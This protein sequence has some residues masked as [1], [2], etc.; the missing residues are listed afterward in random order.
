M[1]VELDVRQDEQQHLDEGDVRWE[2]PR[3]S[4]RCRFL[5]LLSFRKSD[6]LHLIPSR[7]TKLIST[8]LR[9]EVTPEDKQNGSRSL[10]VTSIV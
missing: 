3:R 7:E 10:S 4:G 2:H 8:L 5:R 9:P 6:Q 1:I